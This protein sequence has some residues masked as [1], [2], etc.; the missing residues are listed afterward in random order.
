[1]QFVILEILKSR[2]L[3][4]SCVGILDVFR[5]YIDLRASRILSRGNVST[6]SVVDVF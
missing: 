5:F 4:Q 2:M 6:S 1:V 3:L